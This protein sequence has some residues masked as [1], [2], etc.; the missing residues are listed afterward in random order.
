MKRKRL[1]IIGSILA[2]AFVVLAQTLSSPASETDDDVGFANYAAPWNV[3]SFGVGTMSSPSFQ[4][5]STL[6]QIAVAPA[7]SSSSFGVCSGFQCGSA[8][9]AP[10]INP[11]PA[12]ATPTPAVVPGGATQKSYVP[13][14]LSGTRGC[15]QPGLD[16]GEGNDEVAQAYGPLEL[17]RS[18]Y[19][20]VDG[21][22]DPRDWYRLELQAGAVYE[23]AIHFDGFDN[24]T[25]A[26]LDAVVRQNQAPSYPQV[27]FSS[28]PGLRFERFSFT[29]SVSGS[30]VL[31]IDPTVGVRTVYSLMLRQV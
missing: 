25:N 13:L 15:D 3:M 12:P 8:A 24:L 2:L 11:E 21:T 1:P 26:D 28:T 5:Q 30:Y 18:Y 7:M 6:G 29:A 16:C 4:L 14:V 17:N 22:N 31:L 20:V 10:G 9:G 19:A 27:T 23:I